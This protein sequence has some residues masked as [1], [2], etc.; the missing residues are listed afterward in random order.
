MN[1]Y[2]GRDLGHTQWPCVSERGGGPPIRTFADRRG[3]AC[4]SYERAGVLRVF[5]NGGCWKYPHV[6]GSRERIGFSAGG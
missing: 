2:R 6:R 3:M 4:H 1:V 5:Q